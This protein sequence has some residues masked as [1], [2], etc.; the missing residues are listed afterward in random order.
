MILEVILVLFELTKNAKKKKQ[1]FPDVFETLCF[2]GNKTRAL[3]H[4]TVVSTDRDSA[5]K[6]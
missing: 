5:R 4:D 2:N 3:P 1:S 6:S